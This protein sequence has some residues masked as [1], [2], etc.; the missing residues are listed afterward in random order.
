M[1]TVER[2]VSLATF[3]TLTLTVEQQDMLHNYLRA[4]G[5]KKGIDYDFRHVE[6]RPVG[7]WVY[8]A[9]CLAHCANWAEAEGY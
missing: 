2:L 5:M 9:K 8:S 4:M 3:A 1:S 6:H 7:I